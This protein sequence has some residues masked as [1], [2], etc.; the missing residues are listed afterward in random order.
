MTPERQKL[1]EEVFLAA[2][3]RLDDRRNLG[4][5]RFNLLAPARLDHDAKKII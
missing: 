4:F 1:V 3:S 5:G 2:M